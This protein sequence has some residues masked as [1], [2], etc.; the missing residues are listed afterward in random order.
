MKSEH[1]Y[2]VELGIWLV[3]VIDEKHIMKQKILSASADTSY[4]RALQ[5]TR[6]TKELQ[7]WTTLL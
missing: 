7:M 4:L 2:S 5:N 1:Q 6:D 3:L